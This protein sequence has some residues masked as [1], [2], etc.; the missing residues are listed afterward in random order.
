MISPITVSL[1]PCYELE[2]EVE[3]VK[4]EVEVRGSEVVNWRVEKEGGED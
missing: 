1:E 4:L 2:M 3:E